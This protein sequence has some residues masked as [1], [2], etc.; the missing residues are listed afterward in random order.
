MTD[1]TMRSVRPDVDIAHDVQQILVHYPPL[2]LDRRHVAIDV[3]QG[4]VVLRGH[5]KTPITRRYLVDHAVRT[6]DVVRVD[7][8]RLYTEEDLRLA[9]GGLVPD[10]VMVNVRYG[11]VIL[12]GTLADAAARDALVAHISQIPGVEAV[13]TAFATP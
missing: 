10:G 6:P 3:R 9:A 11:T 7:A 4:V 1:S 2:A 8:D 5:V 13:V 12:N